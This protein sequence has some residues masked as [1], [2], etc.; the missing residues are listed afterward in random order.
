MPTETSKSSRASK[1][2]RASFAGRSRAVHG[3]GFFQDAGGSFRQLELRKFVFPRKCKV[4]NIAACARFAAD[5][6]A[7]IVSDD[8]VE[9]RFFLVLSA[10][11]TVLPIDAVENFNQFENTN[12]DSRFFEQFASDAF[13]ES[14]ANLESAAG[15]GPFTEQRLVAATDQHD[16]SAID[17]HAANPD[18]RPFGILTGRGH[19][20]SPQ[21][22]RQSH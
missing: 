6:F 14:F 18:H 20:A 9:A 5:A 3:K 15:D 22:P 21:V 2:I 10:S 13:L 17:Y 11:G 4:G 1:F 7:Q 16:A 19:S 12:L 8:V